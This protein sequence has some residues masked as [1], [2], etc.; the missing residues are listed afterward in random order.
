[1]KNSYILPLFVVLVAIFAIPLTQKNR[2][3]MG[4]Q[5]VCDANDVCVS[6]PFDLNAWR[7]I[8]PTNVQP[9]WEKR[10]PVGDE[11]E[12]NGG[13]AYC[14]KPYHIQPDFLGY[15]NGTGEW[16]AHCYFAKDLLRPIGKSSWT[17][18]PGAHA[19]IVRPKK[20]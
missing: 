13:A 9:A 16:Q 11:M 8:K 2:S 14:P 10:P 17:C 5:T 6:R 19:E 18:I 3:L 12:D 7:N 4:T 20:K 1:M 15:K